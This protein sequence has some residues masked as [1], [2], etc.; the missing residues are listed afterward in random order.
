MVR[1]TNK[2][3]GEDEKKQQNLLI[4]H[5]VEIFILHQLNYSLLDS[6]SVQ[7]IA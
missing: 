7:T 5:G 1:L 6:P 4:K 3:N 2:K